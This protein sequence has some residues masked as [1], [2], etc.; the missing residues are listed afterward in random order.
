[1]VGRPVIGI[2]A[3]VEPARWGSWNVPTAL[4]PRTYVQAVTA[5][6]GRAVLLPPDD[7]DADV[8]NRLDGLVL[9][10]GADV[11]PVRY[12]ADPHPET[13]SRPGRDAGEL[14]LLDRALALDLPVLGICRGLQLLVVHYGGALH[15]HLPD[16]LNSSRHRPR[17]GVFG[18]QQGRF[19]AG[20][21]AHATLGEQVTLKCHHHQGVA[22]P[23]RLTV[24]CQ[25]DDGLPEAVEDPGRRFVL[26]VQWHPEETTDR[27][28]FAALVHAC[29]EVAV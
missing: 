2:S 19:I 6:G 22:D 24:T 21:L 11:D 23:G 26:G 27:R 5:A 14:L 1:M 15:Q 18:W 20:S 29:A 8:L 10:G 9:S 28:L 7:V 4:I 17:P 16:V 12:G 25:S 3:Y 13:V